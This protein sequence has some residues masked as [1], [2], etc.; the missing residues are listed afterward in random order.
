MM[1]NWSAMAFV[2][3]YLM[4][5]FLHLTIAA[6]IPPS[7]EVLY[8]KYGIWRKSPVETL[9]EPATFIGPSLR[10]TML[11]KNVDL[12]TRVVQEKVF[13]EGADCSSQC[14]KF[15]DM[16][17]PGTIDSGDNSPV[18][19]SEIPADIQTTNERILTI[20]IEEGKGDVKCKEGQ[21][22]TVSSEDEGLTWVLGHVVACIPDYNLLGQPII[23]AEIVIYEQKEFIDWLSR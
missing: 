1:C 4:T 3:L 17:G 23:N 18:D 6:P 19:Q 11:R 20:Q 14:G 21:M 9:Q 15:S 13:E 8:V 22:F 2:R 16:E 10:G 12:G 7:Q 5:I